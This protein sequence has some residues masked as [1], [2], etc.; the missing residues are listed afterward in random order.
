MNYT[1]CKNITYLT[2]S[3]MESRYTP[4]VYKIMYLMCVSIIII[5][6]IVIK[7]NKVEVFVN[8]EMKNIVILVKLTVWLA[9]ACYHTRDCHDDAT[10]N[11][12]ITYYRLNGQRV[13]SV[14]RDKNHFIWLLWRLIGTTV[15][16]NAYTYTVIIALDC[17]KW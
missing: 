14:I 17:L 10:Q 15:Q 6:L 9:S 13:L 16:Q 7:F 8:L 11:L 1:K 12:T 3:S 2:I 4:S 5:V